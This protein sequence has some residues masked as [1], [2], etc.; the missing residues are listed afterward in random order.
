MQFDLVTKSDLNQ[1]KEEIL[2]E[3]KNLKSAKSSTPSFLKSADVRAIL[4]CSHAT[5]Q[6]LRISGALHPT[7]IG[8]T[9]YYH[10][11]EVYD[12]FSAIERLAE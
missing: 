12:L 1:F 4:H 8:G 10:A 11:K 6:N 9:W 7:K 3:I 2:T 5:L